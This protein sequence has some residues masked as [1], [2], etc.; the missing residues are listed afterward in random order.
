MG[1]GV[2]CSID[3]IPDGAYLGISINGAVKDY[4]E[5]QDTKPYLRSMS[6][7]TD[8]EKKIIRSYGFELILYDTGHTGFAN[9]ESCIDEVSFRFMEE[10][11][12]AHHLDFRGLIFIGLALEAPE[13]MY[14]IK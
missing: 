13:G 9:I 3:Y 1:D 5:Y 2:L 8:E 4:F 10:F 6:S 7:M 11:L 12:N 14:K